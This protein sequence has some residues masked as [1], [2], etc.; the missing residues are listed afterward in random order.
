MMPAIFLK[1]SLFIFCGFF[2]SQFSQCKYIMPFTVILF[3]H[4]FFFHLHLSA[5]SLTSSS[6]LY[7][8]LFP[9]PHKHAIVF[10]ILLKTFLYLTSPSSYSSR[11]YSALYHTPT[12][13]VCTGQLHFFSSCCVLSALYCLTETMQV[14]IPMTYTSPFTDCQTSPHMPY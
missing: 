3:F 8:G 4:L 5:P 13:V 12:M 10:L 11:F 7:A 2:T 14:E 1:F 6:T 9:L